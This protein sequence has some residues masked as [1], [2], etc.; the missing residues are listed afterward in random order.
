MAACSSSEAASTGGPA[1]PA[2]SAKPASDKGSGNADPAG[3]GQTSTTPASADPSDCAAADKP[4]C[5]VDIGSIEMEE[6]KL[7]DG[8]PQT[9]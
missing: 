6:G 1:N 4:E 8:P 7:A 9:R 2:A 3:G 5:V